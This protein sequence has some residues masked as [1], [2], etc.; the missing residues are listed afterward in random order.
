MIISILN[1]FK[2]NCWHIK[3]YKLFHEKKQLALSIGG[4]NYCYGTFPTE[5]AYLNRVLN[6]ANCRTVL[7]GCSIEPELLND[8]RIVKDLNRYSLIT[9]RESITYDALLN[10]GI[11]KNTKLYPD[12]AFQL[13]KIDPKLSDDFSERNIV[14]INVSPLIMKYERNKN[15]T[16]ENYR[17]LIRYILQTTEMQIALIPHVVQLGNDDR[18]PLQ[19]LYDEFKES[20][21]VVMI[22]DHNCMELKGYI[23]HLRMFICARTHASI[24]AYSTCVP[25]L[26]TGYSVKANGI[27]KDI[28]GT[29]EHYVVPV[30]SLQKNDELVSAFQWLTGHENVI[31]GYLREFMPSYC[32]K[33]QNA[34]Q[35]IKR[36][37]GENY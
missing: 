6:K 34:G 16:W 35:E 12:P 30:Q 2:I 18:I 11:N 21:R 25:T 7:W 15:I 3:Y 33:A 9:A 28:F 20:G 36:L 32:A 10:A 17:Q 37:I 4:D 27:A 26:V 22:E 8:K 5:L 29:C 23:S 1:K 24:A 14:G 19:V 31:R 13:D